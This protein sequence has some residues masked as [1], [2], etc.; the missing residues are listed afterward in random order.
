MICLTQD[1]FMAE[2]FRSLQGLAAALILASGSAALA[3]LYEGPDR[4]R[5]FSILGTMC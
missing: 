4:T 1:I 3:R 5:A 2:L